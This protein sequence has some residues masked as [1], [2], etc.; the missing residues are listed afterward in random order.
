MRKALCLIFFQ[1]LAFASS[2]LGAQNAPA[3]PELPRLNLDNFSR[4]IQEQIG[5]AYSYARNHPGDAAASGQLGMVLQTYGLLQEAAVC[6]RRAGQIEPKVF[7]WTYLLGAVEADEGKCDAATSTLRLALHLDA[8]YV[9][10]KLRLANCLLAS[11]EW[12]ASGEL[13]AEIVEQHPDNADAYYGLGRVRAARRDLANAAVA[14]HKATELFPEFGA[15]H[16]ALALTYRALGKADQASEQLRFY[17]KNK[18]GVPPAGDPLLAEVRA[19]NRSAT[20]QVQYGAELE[21]QGKLE[22]SAAAHE[23]ALEIDPQLVQAHINLIELYGRLSQFEKAEEH[24]RAA[25]RLNSSS[26]ESYYNYGVLLLSAEEFQ[27]AEDAFRKTIEINPYYSGAHNNLGYLLERRSSFSEAEAEY[28]KAIENKPSDRQAHF[29]LGRVLVNQKKYAEGIQELEK[30]IEPEDENT[31]R[32]V[33][34]LGAAFAR[35][36]DRQNALRYIRQAR[37]GAAARGQS[38]LLASIERDLRALET[39]GTPQ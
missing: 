37:E 31:P 26:A 35:S 33:Y 5:E 23:K 38:T 8:D 1:V 11:A 3:V 4:G 14:Y 29:N 2:S 15:A 7:Q 12:D 39:P 17:E 25:I 24:Y 20:Y 9:P 34:A 18:T 21:R 32:Y 10:A 27:L 16:Y 13:Y 30:T 28:R 22:E 6:Y 19:L 36:G